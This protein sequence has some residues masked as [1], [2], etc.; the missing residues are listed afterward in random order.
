[1][2]K[3]PKQEAEEYLERHNIRGLFKVQIIELACCL[4]HLR[5][6]SS[7]IEN[8][9]D[10]QHISTRLLFAKPDDPKAFLVQV[11]SVILVCDSL[12]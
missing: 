4:K 8:S 6:V 10:W 5:A 3:G 7:D 2:S 9:D 1:M 12:F 11:M